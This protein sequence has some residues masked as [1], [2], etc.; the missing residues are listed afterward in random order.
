MIEGFACISDDDGPTICAVESGKLRL[1]VGMDEQ[2]RCEAVPAQ[3][4]DGGTR[5]R[6]QFLFSN[7]DA[8]GGKLRDDCLVC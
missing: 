4:F 7:L 3:P 1:Q 6:Q 5:R 8:E 2:M